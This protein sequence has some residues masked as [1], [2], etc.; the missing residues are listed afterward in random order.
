MAE[1]PFH[2]ASI[3]ASPGRK[4]LMV[5]KENDQYQFYS[6]TFQK[7]ADATLHLHDDGGED[8]EEFS[9]LVPNLLSKGKEYFFRWSPD[10]EGFFYHAIDGLR[11]HR[12]ISGEDM[13]VD[14]NMKII[15][16]WTQG[17]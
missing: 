16:G 6:D 3:Y 17:S 4:W 8:F 14:G 12:I 7:K 5:G 2:Y 9:F 1:L 15:L 11:Y 10:E 13:L